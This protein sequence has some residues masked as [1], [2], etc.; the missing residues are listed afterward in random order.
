MA[1]TSFCRKGVW[2]LSGRD[3]EDSAPCEGGREKAKSD[4]VEPTCDG[5]DAVLGQAESDEWRQGRG[6]G[7]RLLWEGM[8]W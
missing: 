8:A 7:V 5:W 3:R 2:E 1:V 6:G 4:V